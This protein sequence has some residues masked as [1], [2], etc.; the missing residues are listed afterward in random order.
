[1]EEGTKTS[2]G[3]RHPDGPKG[4]GGATL[5]PP[6]GHLLMPPWS[7]ISKGAPS[8]SRGS[9]LVC[10][11]HE[12]ELSKGLESDSRDCFSILPPSVGTGRD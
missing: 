6:Y 7:H 4:P 8:S 11:P 2:W 9:L 1:M 5:G 12:A 3:E 10:V